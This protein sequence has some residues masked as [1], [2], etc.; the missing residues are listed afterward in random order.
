MYCDEKQFIPELLVSLVQFIELKPPLTEE[1]VKITEEFIAKEDISFS[2][3]EALA[4]VCNGMS[5]DAFRRILEQAKPEKE[6]F[7]D[8]VKEVAKKTK[9]QMWVK[10]VCFNLWKQIQV[11]RT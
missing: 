7:T 11:K 5:E 1:L 8:N 9:M 10:A 6:N 3:T 2:E 4:K